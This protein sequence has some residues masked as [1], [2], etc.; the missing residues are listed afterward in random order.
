MKIAYIL[1]VYWP[2][3]GGCEL[4]TSE[5]VKKMAIHHSVTV[6]TQVDSQ[7]QKL[8]ARKSKVANN[9]FVTTVWAP[10]KKRIYLDS[11]ATV[12]RLGLNLVEKIMAYAAVKFHPNAE[13]LTME[14]LTAIFKIKISS[15]TEGSD[16]IHCIHG[17]VSYLG[18]TALKIAKRRR[19]PFVYTPVAHSFTTKNVE[20]SSFRSFTT[21]QGLAG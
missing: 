7:E 5:L 11:N 21:L 18:L 14:I 19:I 4:H 12:C 6:I 17:G 3:I 9:W 15:L 8:K 10:R 20:K 1:P 16:L 2:A 13:Q